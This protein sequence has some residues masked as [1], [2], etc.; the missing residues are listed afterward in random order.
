[1][2]DDSLI[3]RQGLEYNAKLP[4]GHIVQYLIKE[5]AEVYRDNRGAEI[6]APMQGPHVPECFKVFA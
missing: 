5:T 4:C 1:M 3:L 6:I 2:F